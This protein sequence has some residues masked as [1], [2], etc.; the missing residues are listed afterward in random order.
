MADALTTKLTIKLACDYVDT[1]DLSTVTDDLDVDWSDSLADG[2]GK[3]QADELWHDSRTVTGASED[4]DLAG[5]LTNGLG[6]VV[7]FVKIKTIMIKNTSTTA[8]ENLSV[9]GAA[10]NQLINWVGDASDKIVIGPD[11]LF[12]LHNPAAAG[13]AVTAAT[14]DLLKIDSGA[15]TITYEIVLIGTT[16]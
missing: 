16:A 1:L 13:Y 12:I 9:G 6:D 10:A 2:T 8:G 7:T 11:G 4:L 14:G 3:D 5:S 15:A